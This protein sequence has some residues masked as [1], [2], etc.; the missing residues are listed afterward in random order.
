MKTFSELQSIFEQMKKHRSPE[1]IARTH[2]I[3]LNMVLNQLKIGIPIEHEHTKNEK[4]ATII[5]LQHLDEI[6]D[7]YTRLQKLETK[8]KKKL[9]EE[10]TRLQ[11]T[12]NTYTIFLSWRNI[13]KQI[14]IFFPNMKRPTKDEVSFEINKVYP[15]AIILSYK[16]SAI[17]PTKPYLMSGENK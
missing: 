5:A 2:K 15:G 17:D 3:P 9:K 13:P 6:P 1:E 8:A 14:Q 7:Y 12:G 16:P 10:Y 4:L 11:K